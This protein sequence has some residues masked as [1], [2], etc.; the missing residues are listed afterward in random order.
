VFHYDGMVNQHMFLLADNPQHAIVVS[1]G[2]WEIVRTTVCEK[3]TTQD[4]IRIAEFT[5][6]V[7]RI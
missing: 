7:R 6:Y 1:G 2:D 3:G 4:G 5:H